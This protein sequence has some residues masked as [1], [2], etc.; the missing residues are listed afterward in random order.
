MNKT[1]FLAGT[2][3]GIGLLGGV[4][5]VIG[6]DELRRSL[7]G[8]DVTAPDSAPYQEECGACHM[9]YP[10]GLLPADAWQRVFNNLDDHYGDNA[11]LPPA[12]AK[13]L[14][15]YVLQHAADSGGTLRTRAFAVQAFPAAQAV[16]ISGT[17]YF[18]RKH[19]ELPARLVTGNAQVG[20]FSN[21][22]ACHAQAEQGSFN[23]HQ[24]RIP[25]HGRWDD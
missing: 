12:Q 21:C 1:R 24:V 17:A 19:H 6:D 25:G 2:L 18:K 14:R 4:G 5:L 8:H 3:L 22:D 7:G 16:R 10:P 23:E 13:L 11:E 15:G 20:S 9:A